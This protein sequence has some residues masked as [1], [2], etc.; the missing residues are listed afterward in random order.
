MCIRDSGGTAP[1]FLERLVP[2]VFARLHDYMNLKYNNEYL[3][4]AASGAKAS[5]SP[6]WYFAS[7]YFIKVSKNSLANASALQQVVSIFEA[8]LRFPRN[9][10]E[11]LN[12]SLLPELL[13]KSYELDLLFV[14][15]IIE[16]SSAHVSAENEADLTKLINLIDTC[17]EPHYK[18]SPNDLPIVE[19]YAASLNDIAA[20]IARTCLE[21]LFRI[22]NCPPNADE[23]S[24]RMSD[25]TLPTLLRRCEA[26]IRSF[27]A[28]E[29][30][31]GALAVK[32]QSLDEL[33]FV[34][35]QLRRLELPAGVI[36]AIPSDTVDGNHNAS[37][38][39]LRSGPLVDSALL[40]GN[41]PHLVYLLP[42]LVACA[43]V[44][45]EEAKSHLQAVLEEFLS[46]LGLPPF[47]Y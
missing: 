34:L 30:R 32:K 21:H 35:D 44:R 46:Q 1:A 28:E 41:K 33:L 26:V 15:T 20:T 25:I 5:G 17:C 3:V 39:V 9:V 19:T 7:E 38:L 24:R 13:R 14:N 42:A 29:R 8:Q 37:K 43:S 23:A 47:Q 2:Q 18:F 31:M 40:K 11:R 4:V 22:T 45:E 16:A 6:L 27:L 12:K 10:L 36:T